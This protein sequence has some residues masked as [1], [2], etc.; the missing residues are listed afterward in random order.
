MSSHPLLKLSHCPLNTKLTYSALDLSPEEITNELQLTKLKDKL[1]YVAPSVATDGTG[2]F[3]G[4]VSA[5]LSRAFGP[6]QK[7]N[8]D[9]QFS[10]LSRPGSQTTS[11]PNPP[12]NQAVAIFDSR[13]DRFSVGAF[14]TKHPARH[15][16]PLS[17]HTSS[18]PGPRISPAM[19]L[20]G[21]LR[22]LVYNTSHC[23]QSFHL[24]SLHVRV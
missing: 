11:K 21:I 12:N 24:F 6:K 4:L 9:P 5:A 1:W 23:R 3:E 14:Q 13:K 22:R 17:T 8:P 15:P 20:R 16:A 7:T 10:P 18:R 19:I 2:I